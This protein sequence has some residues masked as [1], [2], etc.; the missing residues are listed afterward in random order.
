MRLDKFLAECNQGIRSE[1]KVLLKSKRVTVNGVT[2]NSGKR[3]IN[4]VSDVVCLDEKKLTYQ[5]FAYYMLNKPKD[6]IT[7][8]EDSVQKTVLDL[9]DKKDRIKGL[10]PVGRLDKDTTGLVLLTNDGALAHN[11]LAPKK[12]V[13]KVYE[14]KIEGIV[15]EAE[16]E[17][18]SKPIELK[19][20]EV[21]K[22]S[23]L[24]VKKADEDAGMS[25]IEITISEGKYHQIKRMF[26]ST[27]MHVLELK[28]LKM[29]SLEL[30][31]RLDPGKYRALTQT[32]IEELKIRD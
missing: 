9:I 1:V 5:S 11:L 15:T 28:R 8:T 3:Q 13:E 16:V 17:L 18:F 26:A 24:V 10:F 29:G 32:E 20:G 31:D 19:N 14:A 2:E 30:D 21:T 4:E 6:V 7:A 22:P 25:E 12:H 23:R 27:G